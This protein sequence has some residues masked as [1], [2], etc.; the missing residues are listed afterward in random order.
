MHEGCVN[1]RLLDSCE[2]P[3]DRW[4]GLWMPGSA[5]AE[6][7]Y[8][9]CASSRLLRANEGRTKPVPHAHS[10]TPATTFLTETQDHA[11]ASTPSSIQNKR[12]VRLHRRYAGLLLPTWHDSTSI[13]L[14]ASALFTFSKYSRLIGSQSIFPTA[15]LTASA[16]DCAS[17]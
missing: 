2:I 10:S 4:L 17:H 13:Q 5:V 9:V 11:C 16:Q 12:E 8:R 1:T 6:C 7:P 3:G 14:P 15:A